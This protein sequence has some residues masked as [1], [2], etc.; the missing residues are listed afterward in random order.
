MV[1]N[2]RNRNAGGS[3]FRELCMLALIIDDSAVIRSILRGYLLPFG[4]NVYEAVDGVDAL[5]LLAQI[6]T[7][8]DLALIDWHMPRMNGLEFLRSIR[9]RQDLAAMVRMMVTSESEPGSIVRALAAG[10]H[11]YLLKPCTADDLGE[12]L[13]YLGMVAPVTAR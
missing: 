12:K 10:A 8:P 1:Y 6:P 9:R 3:V 11:E 13:A 7:V 5:D 2:R 4:F